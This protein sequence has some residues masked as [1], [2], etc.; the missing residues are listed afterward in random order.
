MTTTDTPTLTIPQRIAQARATLARM[1]A[2]CDSATELT[3]RVFERVFRDSDLPDEPDEHEAWI[4]CG[5]PDEES[6]INPD[7]D[8]LITCEYEEDA[9]FHLSARQTEVRTQII[10]YREDAA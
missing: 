4:L 9:Q 1:Q 2:V 3:P 8:T 5:P 7:G 6:A 10:P